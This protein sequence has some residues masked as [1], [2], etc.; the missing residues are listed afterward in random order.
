MIETGDMINE[1]L[2]LLGRH[3]YAAAERLCKQI[4]LYYTV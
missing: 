2:N 3:E 1:A 4:L